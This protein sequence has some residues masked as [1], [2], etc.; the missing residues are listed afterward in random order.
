MNKKK[1]AFCLK[2]MII[3]VGIGGLI[4]YG[5]ILPML[6]NI[7][8][9]FVKDP[10]AKYLWLGFFALTGLPCY[11][12]LVLSWRVCTDIGQERAF[13]V[14]NAI[15]LRRIALLAGFDTIFLLLGNVALFL[16]SKNDLF[17]MAFCLFVIFAGIVLSVAF[18]ALSHLV[19][20][21]AELQDQCDLTI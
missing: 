1:L 15:R 11:A 17:M 20:N 4:V 21:A 3:G 2:T 10:L 19:M 12:V 18:A 6:A 8:A 16:L 13:T 5:L 7:Y 9:P 14:Y